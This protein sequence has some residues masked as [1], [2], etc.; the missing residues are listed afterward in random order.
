MKLNSFFF[1]FLPFFLLLI[2]CGQVVANIR[3]PTTQAARAGSQSRQS[4]I[5]RLNL[6]LVA[7]KHKVARLQ[8][9]LAAESRGRE[10]DKKGYEANLQALTDKNKGLEDRIKELEGEVGRL[11]LAVAAAVAATTA[12]T[13]GAALLQ[14]N[15][16]RLQREL[17]GLQRQL[18]D[19]RAQL[20]AALQGQS[21]AKE[22]TARLRARAD[23]ADRERGTA[24]QAA[25]EAQDN[26]RR[27]E[28]L[29]SG[30][31][32]RLGE[33]DNVERRVALLQQDLIDK[34]RDIDGLRQELAQRGGADVAAGVA[35][36]AAAAELA[37]LRDLYQSREVLTYLP[38]LRDAL[39]GV[40]DATNWQDLRD[41]LSSLRQ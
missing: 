33:L 22:E 21:D 27:L 30:F 32:A 19:L 2:S 6:D 13:G 11:K 34:D 25:A 29:N 26:A 14:Q 28:E 9:K 37:S 16:N 10:A 5:D 31:R 24:D 7:E 39:Q 41:K 3:I 18:N 23:A 40:G 38:G 17:E 12:A 4:E 35:A 15:V 36:A 1:L 20:A 8:E